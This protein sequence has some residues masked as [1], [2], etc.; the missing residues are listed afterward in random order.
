MGECLRYCLWLGLCCWIG[1]LRGQPRIDQIDARAFPTVSVWLQGDLSG[2]PASALSLTDGGA[3]AALQSWQP[4]RSDA[5]LQIAL[6]VDRSADMALSSGL[7][8]ELDAP[9]SR[10]GQLQQVARD[11][12]EGLRPQVDSALLIH[13]GGSIDNTDLSDNFMVLSLILEG[14]EAYGDRV[15]YDAIQYGSEALQPHR[16]NRV[17][18]AL[19]GGADRGSQ[20]SATSL[21]TT[22]QQAGLPLL[23]AY[24]GT[25]VPPALQDLAQ[26]TG[27]GSMAAVGTAQLQKR[28]DSLLMA[29]RSRHQ[30][31]YQ[32]PVEASGQ[33]RLSMARLGQDTLRL[34]AQYEPPSHLVEAR[35]AS[36]DFG[37]DLSPWLWGGVSS[38][39]L[40]GLLAWVGFQVHRQHQRASVIAPTITSLA[41]DRR[42]GR[43][44]V[45]FNL[46]KGRIPAR[47]SVH[48]YAGRP[49]K[50]H[51]VPARHTRTKVDLRDLEEG[52]YHCHLS[53]AGQR[54]EDWEFVWEQA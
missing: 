9:I 19:V 53:H 50:D 27:G 26:R 5:P 34:K 16:G 11:L 2:V 38:L 36:P 43:L 46:P 3:P 41:V 40:L 28:V 18:I 30:L 7:A 6:L 39:L 21:T 48:S 1:V 32:A 45:Q 54:S 15:I 29:W 24:L 33:V 42:K 52:V 25:S 23:I 4:G 22:L 31:V 12:L 10:L 47:I 17:L 49:V 8:S 44:L 13:F 35:L 37:P 14:V 51:V 20:T